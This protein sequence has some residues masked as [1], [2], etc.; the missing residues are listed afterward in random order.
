MATEATLEVSA[1]V[2]GNAFVQQYYH[3]LHHSPE[4]VHRFY[5]DIS[6]LGR[7]EE[8]G[9]MGIATTMQVISF[10]ISRSINMEMLNIWFILVVI[11]VIHLKE[12]LVGNK[13]KKCIIAIVRDGAL[14]NIT[15]CVI[16]CNDLASVS[17]IVLST[18]LGRHDRRLHGVRCIAH[19]NAY[20]II[21]QVMDLKESASTFSPPPPGPQKAPSK[22]I[23]QVNPPLVPTTVGPISSSDAIDIGNNQE[24]EADGHSIYIKGLPM[25]ATE[26]LLEDVFKDF[27]PIKSDGIQ[28][29]SNR[30]FCFG[31]V[32]FEDA[33]SAKKAIEA[34]PVAIGGRRVVVEEKRSTNS[35][36]S[37]RGRFQSGRGSGFRN[38]GVRGRGNYGGGRGYSRGD[39]IARNESNRGGNR[40]GS[41]N[42]GD[43]YHRSDSINGN[44]G[45][46]NR[47][48]GMTNGTNKNMTPRV[49]LTA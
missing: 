24:G 39:F 18:I 22:I 27:G 49:S 2:V 31:F 46:M 12:I 35:R 29:R 43:G 19:R 30:A 33:S 14:K 15:R 34:S 40:G 32:E 3:I 4:L 48:G 47:T 23:E 36:G 7:P 17:S 11:K 25:N 1:Q 16:N 37:N 26:S 20:T 28:V 38:E 42:R 13:I 44:G 6:K 41:S 5:Q 8:D 45:R 9:S 10:S 21:F